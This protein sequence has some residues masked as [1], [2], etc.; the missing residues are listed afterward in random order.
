MSDF[1]LPDDILE[2]IESALQKTQ[3]MEDDLTKAEDEEIMEALNEIPLPDW[4]VEEIDSI[5]ERIQVIEDA[6][7]EWK[8]N[9]LKEA[10]SQFV[11]R[12]KWLQFLFHNYNQ[13]KG[14]AEAI[15]NDRSVAFL[16]Q[17]HVTEDLVS[18]QRKRYVL[19]TL[20]LYIVATE[21][22]R[23]H[24]SDKDAIKVLEELRKLAMIED[25]GQ[26]IWHDEA[27]SM[28]L[29]WATKVID[30]P[31]GTQ[32]G[33]VARDHTG[34]GGGYAMRTPPEATQPRP[35]AQPQAQPQAKRAKRSKQPAR[36]T[37]RT[38]AGPSQ[39]QAEAQPQAKRAK[40]A[41]QPPRS[42]RAQAGP[43][44]QS[45]PRRNARRANK[46]TPR[47]TEEVDETQ[48]QPQVQ[49][50]A[51]AVPP[52]DTRARVPLPGQTEQ[53]A[54]SVP[55]PPTVPMATEA[56][57][58]S[59]P[60]IPHAQRPTGMNMRAEI[61]L[62][63]SIQARHLGLGPDCFAH[64]L[65]DQKFVNRELHEMATLEMTHLV[66]EIFDF[67]DGWNAKWGETPEDE[68]PNSRPHPTI[69]AYA[70]ARARQNPMGL[71][72]A[73]AYK[74]PECPDHDAMVIYLR[75]LAHDQGINWK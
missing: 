60:G 56:W 41:K 68:W 35:E 26:K 69:R 27:F 75:T 48:G 51:T 1:I 3:K 23:I 30:D 61:P 65:F 19:S 74:A 37:V 49:Q 10:K 50:Q 70:L 38:Q 5:N 39:A 28:F 34:R 71:S 45:A 11:E 24:W 15:G 20:K 54:A 52:K 62:F 63:P 9:Q 58:M 7:N 14:Q 64:W 53:A 12:K 73:L 21:F 13:L 44:Q 29:Q 8:Q 59:E 2:E 31:R 25:K 66:G 16:G 22:R 46:A 32:I 72:M 42:M 43:S 55:P 17:Y 67:I 57:I 33:P 47:T 36:S 6:R 40:Q 18:R 4:M